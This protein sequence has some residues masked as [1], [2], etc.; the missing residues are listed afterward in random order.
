MNQQTTSTAVPI[1]G[2]H[3]LV[4]DRVYRLGGEIFLDH[5]VSWC[6]PGVKATQPVNCYLIKGSAGS[7]LVDTGVRLHE[8]EIV[9]QL[10]MLLD[11][12]EPLAIVLTRTEMEC[13]LNVPAIEARFKVK[14]VWY[15]G[16]ITVPRS[17]AEPRRIMVNPGTALDVEVLDGLTLGF[18][19]PLMRLLPT[20]WIFDHESGALLT[21]DA[22]THGSYAGLLPDG[23]AAEAGLRKFQW[24]AEAD[25]RD[26]AGDVEEIVRR[27]EVKA[28]GPGYG[29]PFVGQGRCL[30]EAL[31][32]A[33]AIRKV[34]I[35]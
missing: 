32:L 10:D 5:N 20:L 12:G 24:F 8:A 16:G 25:T 14:S 18:V 30:R 17:S 33:A 11:P 15:T 31:E 3:S 2:V 22:F 27:R 7:V 1:D 28:I 21:S 6:P 23:L 29:V 4:P 35:Q 9:A 26:I 13:C 34:G 19:S